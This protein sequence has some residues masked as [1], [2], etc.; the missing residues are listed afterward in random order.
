MRSEDLK[1]I[2]MLIKSIKEVQAMELANASTSSISK[3]YKHKKEELFEDLVF[4][5]VQKNSD[6]LNVI[7]FISIGRKSFNIHLDT[8]LWTYINS[9][10]EKNKQILDEESVVENSKFENFLSRFSKFL[11]KIEEIEGIEKPFK[12]TPKLNLGKSNKK[13]KISDLEGLV[14][15]ME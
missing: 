4:V 1:P 12:K 3:Q 14:A 11:S 8:D 2:V 6:L 15:Q 7:H 13:E 5:M 9:V 10:F